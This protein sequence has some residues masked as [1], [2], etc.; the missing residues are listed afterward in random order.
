MFAEAFI[1]KIL[2][3]WI[4]S[5]MAPPREQVG[6]RVSR[7]RFTSQK[8]QWKNPSRYM[9]RSK[10]QQQGS[11][12]Q[13]V[14][15]SYEPPRLSDLQRQNRVRSREHFP[16]RRKSV[17]RAP[18]NNS[19]FLMR[20]RQSGG[21]GSST[22]P[23]TPAFLRTPVFQSP[24]LLQ[25]REGLVEEVK[26]LGVDGYGSMA[27]LIHLRSF[28]NE[29]PSACGVDNEVSSMADH[30]QAP[31]S[32]QQVEERLDHGVSRFELTYPSG[33]AMKSN[34]EFME[35]RLAEQESH[36]AYLED[37]NLTLKER[38]FLVQQEATELRQRLQGRSCVAV[39]DDHDDACSD[40]GSLDRLLFV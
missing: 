21:L 39:V 35:V 2:F 29:T 15:S 38:L 7:W 28:N 32:V 36:I 19:S 24:I 31:Q 6:P 13:F 8:R 4:D 18:F 26:D 1:V 40:D 17:P 27:G 12:V 23:A 10:V 11:D 25:Y 16:K 37:E 33:N 5:T 3:C 30:V 9:K 14:I 34:V 20:V 22:S